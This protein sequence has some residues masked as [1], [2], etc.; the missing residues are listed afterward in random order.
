MPVIAVNG[1][2]KHERGD[3]LWLARHRY[4]L[5]VCFAAALGLALRCYGL[6]SEPLNFDEGAT[7]YFARVPLSYL[8]GDSA[9]FEPNPPLFYA[10]VHAFIWLFGDA[11]AVVRSASVMAGV[12]CIPAAAF[13]GRRLA[14]PR[15]GI[16]AAL[17]V[18]TSAAHIVTSQDARAYSLLT[19]AALAAIAAEVWLLEAYRRPG[20]RG[21]PGLAGA[22]A[23]YVVASVMGMYLHNTAVLMVVALNLV[24]ALAWF[25]TLGLQ[26]RFALHWIA[27][28]LAIVVAYI[29]WVPIVLEQSVHTLANFW[30]PT[31]TLR[32]LRYAMMNV[33]A[34]PHVTVFQPFADAAFLAAGLAGV[35]FYR[36]NR[37]LLG[38]AVFV[39]L[40]VPAASWLI[41]QWRPI[42]NGKTLMWLVPVFLV[43]VALGCARFKRLT[44]PAVAGLV[45]IQ[46]IGCWSYFQTRPDEAFP[47]VTAVLNARVR[48]GDVMLL[49][50]AQLEVLLDYY[51]WPRDKL[52]VYAPPDPNSWY[53]HDRATVL[54]RE[55]EELGREKRVWVLSRAWVDERGPLPGRL[56]G[57]MTET[58]SRKFGRGKM[59]N[60]ELSLL[61][62]DGAQE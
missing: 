31:P 16:A 58:F 46:L 50:S 35:A 25:W 52:T 42:M 57:T 3:A 15:A 45:L 62:R 33:Y 2:A 47:E 48:Q 56:T 4:A 49:S 54:D 8:W 29:P 43:L 53:R 21:S 17:L 5:I 39:I 11:A 36:S 1:V 34:Q 37:V 44:A 30:I 18:A 61:A 10:T 12:L 27:A 40:G 55:V 22:W 13:I 19:L 60:L 59:R 9:R 32:D 26:R 38:L 20:R 41:S 6:A 24:A 7:L 28:N 51:G 14:G 23:V